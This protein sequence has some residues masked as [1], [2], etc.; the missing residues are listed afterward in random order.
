MRQLVLADAL[1]MS[2]NNSMPSERV[3]EMTDD[4]MAGGANINVHSLESLQSNDSTSSL[5]NVFSQSQK[6]TNIAAR[7]IKIQ[8]GNPKTSLANA[9]Q[10]EPTDRSLDEVHFARKRQVVTALD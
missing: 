10:P 1:V 4:P 9:D 5:K 8:D 3:S 6:I 2:K 7:Y